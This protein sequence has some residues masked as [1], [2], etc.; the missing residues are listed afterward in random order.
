MTLY[1]PKDG[2]DIGVTEDN[3]IGQLILSDKKAYVHKMGETKNYEDDIGLEL[4]GLY[5]Y[6]VNVDKPK[7]VSYEEI[8][9]NGQSYFYD[10]TTKKV[11]PKE[12]IQKEIVKE[13]VEMQEMKKQAVPALP[14]EAVKIKVDKVAIARHNT[15][16]VLK[17]F[18][19]PGR[20]DYAFSEEGLTAD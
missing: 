8:E 9:L 18:Q 11:F 7:E 16:N 19:D 6:L 15:E 1:N 14:K 17:S 3:G 12:E 10:P 4:M 20:S 5:P 2:A 13:A